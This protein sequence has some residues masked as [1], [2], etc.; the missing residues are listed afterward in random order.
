MSDLL[1][2]AKDLVGKKEDK[3]AQAGDSVER[4]ADDKINNEVNNFAS[5]EGIP[6]QFDKGIDDVVDKKVNSDIPGGN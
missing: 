5:Q 6:Q 4:G 1:D 3:D 2:K